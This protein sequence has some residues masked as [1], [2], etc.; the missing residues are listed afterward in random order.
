M[1]QRVVAEGRLAVEGVED[2]AGWGGGGVWGGTSS[3]SQRVMSV[4][5]GDRLEDAEDPLIDADAVGRAR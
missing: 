4:V 1:R 2:D 5:L 3:R